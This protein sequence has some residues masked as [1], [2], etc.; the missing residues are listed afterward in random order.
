MKRFTHIYTCVFIL[1]IGISSCNSLFL[2]DVT[3]NGRLINQEIAISDYAV[4]ELINTA[5]VI[6][7]QKSAKT[8]YL[9]VYIDENLIP[10]I[11]IRVNGERLVITSKDGKNLRP[12]QFKIYTNS[13][14]LKTVQSKGTGDIHLKGE[15]NAPRMSIDIRGTG[16]VVADSL[17][18]E[19]LKVNISGTGNARLAGVANDATFQISGTGNIE[20]F[21]Y[22]L[23]QLRAVSS[24]TGDMDVRVSEY[25]DVVISG[26]G[27]IRYVGEPK[28]ID[29]KISGT[30]R[31]VRR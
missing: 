4:I 16:D 11:D 6:Y 21:D 26:T 19:E 2:S 22:F 5:N 14:N 1:Y 17:Y 29:K 27:D 10:E 12:T 20:A 30:G 18:C 13:R 3:G 31:L 9:Q 15:V 8:P 28:K 25:L 23:Q 24:G 7:E